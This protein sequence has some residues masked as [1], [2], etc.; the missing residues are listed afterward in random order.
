VGLTGGIGSGKSAV[1][2]RLAEHGAIVVDADKLARDVVAPGTPGLA[3]VAEAFGQGVLRPDGSLNREE[4]GKIVFADPAARRRL[5]GITH[6][7][8]RAE[9]VRRFT[10]PAPDA[11]VVHDIPLLV[12]AGMAGGYDVVV[13]V[14]AP[15]AL[16]LERLERRGLPRDQA[17]ARMASQATDEARRAVAGVVLDNS[18]TLVDLHAQVD[19]LWADLV[20]R[21][22]ASA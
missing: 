4:L 11:V 6:P 3:A 22:A 10:E 9:T 2:S 12:E 8:I 20:A 5:E 7:L 21:Q 13:V 15:R 16:R 1:S 18:G 19:A 17:E 14:E